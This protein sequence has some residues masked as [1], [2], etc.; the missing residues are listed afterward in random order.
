MAGA[1]V[2]GLSAA[3]WLAGRGRPVGRWAEAAT[4]WLDVGGRD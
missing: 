4:E 3:V 2:A 1:G